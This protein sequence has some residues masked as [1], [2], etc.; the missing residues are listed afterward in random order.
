MHASIMAEVERVRRRLE[1][2]ILEGHLQLPELT[3]DQPELRCQFVLSFLRLL[4]KNDTI[5][6]GFA[7]NG[8]T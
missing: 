3:C 8:S 4:H 1:P 6:Y 2:Y 5:V 7:M